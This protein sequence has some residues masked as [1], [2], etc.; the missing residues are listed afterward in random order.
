MVASCTRPTGDFG[1]ATPSVVNDTLLPEAGQALRYTTKQNVSIFNLT[2]DEEE[3]RNRAW[4]LIAPPSSQDWIGITATEL[5]RT[6]ILP[7]K[8]LWIDPQKYYDVLRSETYR[9]SET[10]YSRI[11]SDMNSDRSL[12]AP[13]CEVARR[14]ALADRERR[15]ALERRTGPT[16]AEIA[17]VY[18]RIEEND[19]VT[20]W[21][22]GMATVRLK[23][24]R[25]AKNTLEL[26]TPSQDKVWDAN[27]AYDRLTEEY[28]LLF[29][30]C[31]LQEV[32]D[33]RSKEPLRS[34]VL[35]GWGQESPPPQK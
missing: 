7:E 13:Y 17:G 28:L 33:R 9:S 22:L 11:I 1:R 31:G 26:E 19:D 32:Q 5:R 16:S 35:Q 25:I 18:A 4:A 21:V 24:Y 23:A 6:G 29:N 27:Q 15:Q 14:V 8:Y 2:D 10:R 34:R 20:R 12:I 3:M 30:S